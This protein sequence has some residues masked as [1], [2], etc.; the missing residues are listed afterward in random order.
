MNT[1]LHIYNIFSCHL[2]EHE[3]RNMSLGLNSSKQLTHKLFQKLICL[4]LETQGI[5][6]QGPKCI[7]KE[8]I[9]KYLPLEIKKVDNY[10][11]FL[12]SI[13]IF[14]WQSLDSIFSLAV[15]NDP[16]EGVGRGVAAALSSGYT[17]DGERS[18]LLVDKE[19]VISFDAFVLGPN[20]LWNWLNCSQ[21]NKALTKNS[22]VLA[23]LTMHG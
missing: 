13:F 1:H 6:V 19:I 8:S 10:I 12:K 11:N 5:Y 16:A 9:L 15:T 22:G 21:W 18:H 4:Y 2:G 7:W 17:L 14:L 20:H 23:L 3:A